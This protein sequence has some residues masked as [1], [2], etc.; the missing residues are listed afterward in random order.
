MNGNVCNAIAYLP[1]Y[2]WD[3]NT[4]AHGKGISLLKHEHFTKLPDCFSLLICLIALLFVAATAESSQMLLCHVAP[5]SLVTRLT[6][7]VRASPPASRP[8]VE[9]VRY[10]SGI[11]LFCTL[12][13]HI[14]PFIGFIHE[15]TYYWMHVWGSCLSF[16]AHASTGHQF[17]TSTVELPW[18]MPLS[19]LAYV[20]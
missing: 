3:A 9:M 20:L 5:R 14:L 17:F 18:K 12:Q 11:K 1:F 15:W 7:A 10:N 6:D 4:C 16:L 2:Q 8:L 13:E 19:I